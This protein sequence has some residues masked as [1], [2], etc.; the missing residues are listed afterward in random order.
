MSEPKVKAFGCAR[1]I[2]ERTA[3]KVHEGRVLHYLGSIALEDML[4]GACL[5]R[6]A[7]NYYHYRSMSSSPYFTQLSTR[8]DIAKVLTGSHLISI[9]SN[10]DHNTYQDYIKTNFLLGQVWFG[11]DKFG[12]IM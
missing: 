4:E 6:K 11:L 8:Q 5:I 10:N 2:F 12:L 1:R 3:E 7:Q 9:I